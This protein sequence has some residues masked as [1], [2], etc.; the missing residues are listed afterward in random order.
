MIN[1]SPSDVGWLKKKMPTW[2][3]GCKAALPLPANVT[4]SD[5]CCRDQEEKNGGKALF[6]TGSLQNKNMYICI[7]RF[8]YI[9]FQPTLHVYKFSI[10]ALARCPWRIRTS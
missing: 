5:I 3:L 4:Q 8:V 6:G 7:Y 2:G 1:S 9:H 10:K